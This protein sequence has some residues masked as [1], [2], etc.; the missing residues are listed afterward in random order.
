MFLLQTSLLISFIQQILHTYSIPDGV[1]CN[2]N[3]MVNKTGIPACCHGAYTLLGEA[4]IKQIII[5]IKY[6][7]DLVPAL[8][9]T[10]WTF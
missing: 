4:V 1:P 2:G 7:K 8:C 5:L 3:K 6:S 10:L 9:K